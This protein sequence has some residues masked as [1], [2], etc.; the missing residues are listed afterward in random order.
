MSAFWG[1]VVASLPPPIYYF[2]IRMGV[3]S[4]VKSSVHSPF[5]L[6]ANKQLNLGEHS[7]REVIRLL[8]SAHVCSLSAP[9][10][11]WRHPLRPSLSYA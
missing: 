7:S 8:L 6:A 3:A 4:R 11:L 9:L 2:I 10:R 1:S 5:I